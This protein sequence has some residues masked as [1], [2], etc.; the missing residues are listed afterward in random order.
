MTRVYIP[1]TLFFECP[2]IVFYE[3]DN[4]SYANLIF[5]QLRQLINQFDYAINQFDYQSHFL[6]FRVTKISICVGA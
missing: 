2:Y 5:L 4:I 6:Q 3:V 1:N